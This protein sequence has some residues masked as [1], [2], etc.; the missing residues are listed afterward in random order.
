ML[1]FGGIR[2]ENDVLVTE[3]GP[4]VL[5]ADIPVIPE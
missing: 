5:T 2:I 1:G 4:E 3:A